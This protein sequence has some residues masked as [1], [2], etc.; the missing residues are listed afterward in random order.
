MSSEIYA[1]VLAT[2]APS[3]GPP[4]GMGVFKCNSCSGSRY[5][6]TLAR[7]PWAYEG[8]PVKSML[9]FLVH[10]QVCQ[11][12]RSASTELAKFQGGLGQLLKAGAPRNFAIFPVFYGICPS[13]Q[14][15]ARAE[16]GRSH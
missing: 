13:P 5:A 8:F 14:A 11:G 1:Q 9:E 16:R 3:Q 2:L 6:R 4:G 7:P 10:S 12:P 15:R